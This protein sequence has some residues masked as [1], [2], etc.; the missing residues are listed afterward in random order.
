MF[1]AGNM[2]ETV[3]IMAKAMFVYCICVAMFGGLF[4]IGVETWQA[5]DYFGCGMAIIS[6]I[7]IL[8]VFLET[9][10]FSAH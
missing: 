8:G 1:K 6:E 5:A 10:F 9:F 2:K 3:K 4:M 7:G